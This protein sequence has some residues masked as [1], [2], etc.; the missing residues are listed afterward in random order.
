MKFTAKPAGIAGWLARGSSAS[1]HYRATIDAS[2]FPAMAAKQAGGETQATVSVDVTDGA[3]RWVL[4]GRTVIGEL[5]W[6]TLDDGSATAAFLATKDLT[7]GVALFGLWDG[8]TAGGV[9]CQ[10]DHLL[11]WVGAAAENVYTNRVA[12]LAAL[13]AAE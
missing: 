9:T 8:N 4:C 10:V 5:L 13:D 11:A 7:N 12:L 6:I 1:A 3:W 2:G